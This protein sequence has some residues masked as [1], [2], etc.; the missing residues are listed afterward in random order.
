MP[1]QWYEVRVTTPAEA[2]DAVAN[3]LLEQGSP[4]LQSDDDGARVSLTAYFSTKPPIEQL[5]RFCTEI[6][7]PLDTTAIEMRRIGEEDWA[8][9]WKLHFQ[10]Q[11]I[12]AHLYVCP[13]WD[14]VA[15]PGRRAI[16]IDPGM[17]FGTGQ[18][19]STRGCLKLLDWAV[20]THTVRRALD[21]GTG[22]G[23]LA[24]ALAKLDV[25]TVWAV[26]TDPQA[27]AVARLNAARNG[28]QER[29]EFGASLDEFPGSADLI[30]ANL[31]AV[32]LTGLAERLC[33]LTN[34]CGIVICS[35]LLADEEQG[36][37]N[38]YEGA[39]LATRSHE[40]EDGWVTLAFQR[41]AD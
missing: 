36:V 38:A 25:A 29:I 14:S 28:V 37:R 7:F 9:N 24:I 41:S 21:L 8:H 40:E 16:V 31:F 26:D 19:A 35:G 4:G 18:H 15:P 1:R 10:P 6:G 30:V 20:G 23:V 34:P 5:R 39:G 33:A 3:F 27:L 2:G 17:A 22:S 11:C 32:M 13:P 12:G